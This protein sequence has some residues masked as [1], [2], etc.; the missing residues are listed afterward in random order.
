MIAPKVSRTN[1]IQE[2]K[3][4]EEPS[5]NLGD[6]QT[7]FYNIDT[8]RDNK[9]PKPALNFRSKVVE[10]LD[11]YYMMCFMGVLSIWTLFGDDIRTAACTKS[12]DDTFYAVA[13]ACFSVF[14]FEFLV[15]CA[16][17]DKYIFS[18]YFWLDLVST[19]S[20]IPDIGWMW[21]PIIGVDEND[22]G[23]E[24]VYKQANQQSS[25]ATSAAKVLRIVRLIRLIR[26]VRLYKSASSAI[27]KHESDS[28]DEEEVIIPKESQVGKRLSDLTIK[29]VIIIILCLLF[30][31]PFFDTEMYLTNYTSWDYGIQEIEAFKGNT[32]VA[33]VINEY[34]SYHEDD[35]RPIIYFIIV[36]PKIQLFYSWSSST[37]I[38]D[39][40][41]NEKHF[42]TGD[43]SVAVFD[44]RE[45]TKFAA[46][47]NICQTI[48]I[49][50][51]LTLGAIYF[52]KDAEDLVIKPIEKMVERVHFI[53]KNP[54]SAAHKRHESAYDVI[55]KQ[56]KKFLCFK[57]KDNEDKA[58]FEIALLEDTIIKIGVLLALGFG[59]AGGA[60]IASNME[61][62]GD[63]EL[64]K[65]NKIVAV[66]GF[67]DI[68]NFTD[69][70]EE[71]QEAVMVFVNEIARIVHSMVDT[72]HG[73][74]NKNIGD[75]F[76][77][78]WKFSEKDF[79]ATNDGGIQANPDSMKAKYIPDLALFSFLKILA[80]I[81]KDP[82]I[83]K[84]R[85]HTKLNLRMPNYEVKM[86]FGL[87]IGWAIEGAIGSQFKIDASYLSP[88]VNMAS[89]FEAA[90]KQ[91][92][93][94]LLF[95]GSLYD[96]LSPNVQAYCRHIDTVTVKG[97][98]LPIR[99]YTSDS[100]FSEFTPSKGRERTK[101]QSR[102]KRRIL[103]KKLESETLKSY[104]LYELSKEIQLMKKPFTR[105]FYRVFADGMKGYIEGKWNDAKER[106]EECLKLR[107]RDGPSLTLL[108]VM[109]EC[110]FEVPNDWKGYRVLTEK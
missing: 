74:A 90:T 84:Y 65:G 26:I 91:Y 86:G 63:L 89:R 96:Y 105:E 87:H 103:E 104:E 97:S 76:L 37:Q 6:N 20:L 60:I 45:D 40:R 44:L 18:F 77:L 81:N 101:Q 9:T 10:I 99:I 83:L 72:Y 68:R 61:K 8:D 19:L 109:S 70:T 80:K 41:Y 1:S 31:L 43:F 3:D 39:L 92:G 12:D 100:D 56:K 54:I 55:L 71:L 25:F 51:V 49:C 75:A 13:T 28:E 36:V 69:S 11:S 14:G 23:G 93:V 24:S 53:A 17:K 15:C 35:R 29:R 22:E 59:E 107:P 67:C 38:S 66:F 33:T 73:A 34:I 47:L 95:S 82:V 48:F 78:V 21:D 64:V 85:E 16:C 58:K 4:L 110:D 57:L 79:A 7:T 108:G 98:I 32:D 42:A 102:H 46:Q 50:I 30:I 27:E 52:S 106:F 88:H 2:I 62:G 94:P 5:N